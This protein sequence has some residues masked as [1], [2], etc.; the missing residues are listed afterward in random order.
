MKSMKAYQVNPI[1]CGWDLLLTVEDLANRIPFTPEKPEYDPN[2]L[3]TKEEFF[4][5]FHQAEILA[6]TVGWEGDYS[7]KPRVFIIPGDVY[8]SLGFVWKHDSNGTCFI[9]LQDGNSIHKLSKDLKISEE[10][11][12]RWAEIKTA[13]K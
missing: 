7:G 6:A 3:F 4:K 13:R 11:R 2:W 9:I 10:D 5:M 8:F 12:M 1:D